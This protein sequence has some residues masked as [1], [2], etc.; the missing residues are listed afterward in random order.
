MKPKKSSEIL[1]REYVSEILKE[2]QGGGIGSDGFGPVAS[3][4]DIKKT[5][6]APFSDVLGTL[7]AGLKKIATKGITLLKV[8]FETAMT[9][10]VPFVQDSYKEIFQKD[11]AAISKIESEHKEY[12]EATRKAIGSDAVGLAFFAFPGASLAGIFA[13]RSPEAARDIL[14]TLTVGR[15]EEYIGSSKEGQAEGKSM[16]SCAASYRKLILEGN[17]VGASLK[18]RHDATKFIKSSIENSPVASDVAKDALEAMKSSLN[19]AYQKAKEPAECRSIED[20]KKLIPD[21]DAKDFEAKIANMPEDERKKE[22]QAYTAS[23]KE[24]IKQLQLKSLEQRKEE[25][26]EKLGKDHPAVGLYDKTIEAI[27]AIK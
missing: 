15:S 8:A 7:R 21:L 11:K 4:T 12:Y 20:L 2:Y 1:V 16:Y 22:E 17:D 14:N 24:E 26:E 18:E 25:I 9:S 10:V 19:A 5:F 3:K 23:I 13:K 27:K 6:I